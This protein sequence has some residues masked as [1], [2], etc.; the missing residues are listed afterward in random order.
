MKKL[1]IRMKITLWF[2]G[3]LVMMA[4][5]TYIVV[6]LI[7]DAILQKVL[8]DNLIEIVEDNVDEVEYRSVQSVREYKSDSDLYITYK[9]GYLEIDDDFLD[10][11]NGICTSLYGGE[12]SL[13]YG[14]NPISMH[15]E[16]VIFRD[17]ELRKE[18]VDGVVWYV[19]DRKLTGNGLEGLWLRGVVSSLQAKLRLSPLVRV[20]M[21][22]IPLLLTV[23]IGGG[24]FIAG[25][26][27]DPLKKITETARQIGQ[28]NELKKRIDLGEGDDELHRLANTFDEMFARLD[29]SFEAERRFASDA[30]HELRTPM[31]V[32][33]AQCEYSL[34]QERSGKE[35][36]EALV[37]IRRQGRKMT[38][39]ISDMLSF[40]RMER[41]TDGYEMRMLDFSELVTEVCEDMKRLPEKN[42][43]LSYA[44]GEH[45]AVKGNRELLTRLLVNLVRNAYRYGTEDGHIAVTLSAD[46]TRIVLS[47]K[48]DG[49]GIA[50]EEQEKIFVRFYQA[51][52]S[53]TGEGTGLGLSMVREIARLHGGSIS[54]TSALG[55]GSTFVFKILK[56]DNS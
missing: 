24:Y 3:M 20:L 39:L 28:G 9:G 31:A 15:S 18:R 4:G 32:I 12:D 54:V 21:I 38:R 56:S 7:S 30:S 19:F 34:E 40:V 41:G 6:L 25:R 48:D 8:V 37:V 49:I 27:L 14:D 13:I 16:K 5:F 22:L 29:A 1:S 42:I 51:D 46:E 17:M 55:E 47:V 35:Y 2:S 10:E 53:R 44:A 11:M 23:A 43:S 52:C 45:I 36:R 26:L 33:M 50:P